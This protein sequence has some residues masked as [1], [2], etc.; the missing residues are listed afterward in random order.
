MPFHYRQREAPA[1]APS[2]GR[3]KRYRGTDF[4]L[5]EVHDGAQ[6]RSSGGLSPY[7]SPARLAPYA[8][9]GVSADVALRRHAWN[10]RICE[11]LYP[12][13]QLLEVVLRNQVC[14]GM[15]A[16]VGADWMDGVG[17]A[18]SARCSEDLA[19][20]R[21]SLQRRRPSFTRDDRIAALSLGF[22]CALHGPHYE[23][24]RLCLHPPFPTLIKKVYPGMPKS[25]HALHRIKSDLERLRRLRNRVFH[26]ERILHWNDLDAQV[27]LAQSYLDWMGAE[28]AEAHRQLSRYREVRTEQLSDR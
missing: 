2:Q 25:L 28:A 7:L 20:V 27:D 13:L 5:G 16:V 23:Q 9:D 26:H 6:G 22:W 12:T 24:G 3:E 10:L 1:T 21:L 17:I 11:S 18:H 19:Q 15:D 8:A 14:A 4:R